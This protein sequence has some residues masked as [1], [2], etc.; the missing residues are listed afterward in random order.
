MFLVN[1][2][3]SIP[4]SREEGMLF[5]DYFSVKERHHLRVLV[6]QVLDLEVAA[7]VGG[8]LVHVLQHHLHVVLVP[9][10]LLVAGEPRAVVEEAAA[11]TGLVGFVTRCSLHCL[12]LTCFELKG[13]GG[14]TSLGITFTGISAPVSGH[15]GVY[16]VPLFVL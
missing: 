4:L 3:V 12:L 7:Q 11:D 5:S 13:R 2:L 9:L 1:I 15:S 16:L 10:G 8:V 14:D 6:R